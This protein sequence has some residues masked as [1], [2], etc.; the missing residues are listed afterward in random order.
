VVLFVLAPK[1]AKLDAST[2]CASAQVQNSEQFYNGRIW[3][4]LFCFRR[5]IDIK[6]S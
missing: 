1:R 2:P 6:W 4:C 3:N 5:G